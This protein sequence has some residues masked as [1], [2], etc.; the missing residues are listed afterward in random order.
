MS[1]ARD[2]ALAL[3]REHVNNEKTVAHCLASEA[4]MRALARRL[5]ENDELWGLCGLLHDVDYEL[6]DQDPAMHGEKGAQMILEAGFDPVVAEVVR[7]HN[8]E[9]LGLCRDC[10]LD[11]SLAAAETVTGLIVA[12]ALVHPEKKLAPLTRIIHEQFC[13]RSNFSLVSIRW[14]CFLGLAPK[15]V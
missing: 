8:A 14:S 15:T 7:K 6:V 11:F 1:S 4:V 2:K 12:A 3:L 5:G 9:G 13:P 10:R